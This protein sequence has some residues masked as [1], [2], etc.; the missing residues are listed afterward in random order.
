MKCHHQIE[1]I[2]KIGF[3]VSNMIDSWFFI[4]KIKVYWYADCHEIGCI[5]REIIDDL[6]HYCITYDCEYNYF[7]FN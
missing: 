3:S 1:I 2:I 4:W 5:F 7:Y 6:N